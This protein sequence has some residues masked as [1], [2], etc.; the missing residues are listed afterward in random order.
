MQMVRDLWGWG[1]DLGEEI[2]AA[3]RASAEPE[4][5]ASLACLR[6]EWGSEGLWKAQNL[7][8]EGEALSR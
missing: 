3:G 1:A 2:P 8:G 7:R 4:A 5:S 6:S